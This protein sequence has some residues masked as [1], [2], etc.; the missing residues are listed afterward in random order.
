[1]GKPEYEFNEGCPKCGSF[2]PCIRFHPREENREEYLKC[3]CTSCGF[4]YTMTTKEGISL[5]SEK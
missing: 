5:K 3:N 2:F 1:M 4:A